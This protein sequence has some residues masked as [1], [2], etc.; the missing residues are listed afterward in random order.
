MSYCVVKIDGNHSL[1]STNTSNDGIIININTSVHGYIY[2]SGKTPSAF[3][4]MNVTEAIKVLTNWGL[5]DSP[6]VVIMPATP[7]D[8]INNYFVFSMPRTWT[9]SAGG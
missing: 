4:F 1:I 6:D 2:V 5:R 9:Y 7:S 8:L 3:V